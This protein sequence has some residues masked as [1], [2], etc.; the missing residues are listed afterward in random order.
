MIDIY[1]HIGTH[2]T[3][4]SYI[5]KSFK[6]NKYRL[7]SLKRLYYIDLTK[8]I[9]KIVYRPITNDSIHEFNKFINIEM[10]KAK[11]MRC[12]KVF[13]CSE[14]LSGNV[15]EGYN[16]V[17]LIANVLKQ[18]LTS[19]KPKIIL[20]LR[21]HIDFIDSFYRQL[22]HQGK[23]CSFDE[24]FETI[25]PSK[26]NWRNV[27]N[28]YGKCFG[29]DSLCVKTYD[30]NRFR[31]N[32]SILLE[33]FDI[34]H[35]SKRYIKF[36]DLNI[37]KSFSDKSIEIAQIVNSKLC[38]SDYQ[39]LRCFIQ[40]YQTE[41]KEKSFIDQ[42]KFMKL[43]L[44]YKNMI[45]EIIQKYNLGNSLI[46]KPPIEIS[47]RNSKEDLIIYLTKMII[48]SVDCEKRI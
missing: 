22:I 3:G 29:G 43:N 17:G 26:Y 16:N 27:I 31:S 42:K 32:N 19:Y 25:T 9:K 39:K 47:I 44:Y 8:E 2:K 23:N 10:K 48:K 35:I 45:D 28:E 5:Q 20:Y 30:E 7:I 33:I 1:I 36:I 38:Q 37:N 11:K 18:N 15:Y 41:N 14:H 34:L 46:L 12:K 4:T 40:D 21:N 13:I 24:Y 6:N